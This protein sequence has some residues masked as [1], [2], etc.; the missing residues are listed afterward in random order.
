MT[1]KNDLQLKIWKNA[2][3]SG[4]FDL[5]RQALSEIAEFGNTTILADVIQIYKG[6]VGTSIENEIFDFLINIKQNSAKKIFI[7]HIK[8]NEFSR[9]KSKLLSVL[10]QS[11]LD[12]SDYADFFVDIFINDS[13]ENAFEALT[14]LQNSNYITPENLHTLIDKLQMSVGSI[15]DEKKELLVD[16]V[17]IL[18]KKVDNYSNCKCGDDCT[19]NC[20]CDDEC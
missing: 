11:S 19:G 15:A 16:L 13:F 5:I 2:L 10:W 4:D 17:N 8:N 7:D 12:Y 6:Y 20:N 18:R 9:I 3:F 14:I 1:S